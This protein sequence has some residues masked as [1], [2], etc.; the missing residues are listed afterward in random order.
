MK[1]VP[2]SESVLKA[3]LH[4]LQSKRDLGKLWSTVEI[5]TYFDIKRK[6]ASAVVNAKGFPAAIRVPGVGRRWDP[7]EVKR[8][9]R[10]DRE[11][12]QLRT[13]R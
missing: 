12:K 1:E 3:I 6:S 7:E 10:A 9:A 8:W 4:E 13:I 5:G 2:V 11:K